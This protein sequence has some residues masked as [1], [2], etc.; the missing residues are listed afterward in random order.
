MGQDRDCLAPGHYLRRTH[1]RILLTIAILCAACV[2]QFANEARARCAARAALENQLL[3]GK[4]PSANKP[5]ALV[6]S[7]TDAPAWKRV[8][9]GTFADSFVL[10]NALD[11]AG[12][13]VG[14][15]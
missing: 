2:F 10:R 11:E 3:V 15:L 8:K 12:C 7:A 14:A 13:W 9:I 1:R 5:P 4:A 6:K